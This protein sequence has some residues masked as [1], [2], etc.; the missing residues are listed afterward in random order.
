MSKTIHIIGAGVSGLSAAVRL[1]NAGLPVHVHEATQQAGG[2]CRSYFDAATNLTIDNGNH[3][4][5]S[6]NHHVRDYARAIGTEAGLVGPSRAQFPFVDIS[7]G[8]R[9]LLDLGD[10]RLPTWVFDESRRV[11]DT[12][13]FDYLKLAP[14]VWAGADRMVGSTIPCDGTLYERLVQPLLLAALNCDPPE[15]SAGLAGAI[16]RETLLAGGQACRPLIARD[17]LSAVLIE[18]AVKLL[19][20]RAPACASATSFARLRARPIA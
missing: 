14:I 12:S 18:P 6:G 8:Q 10:S 3:L 20:G 11:P 5:L 15:G 1:S 9:W 2:R 16:V 17:G 7:T 13:L 4:V 19:E